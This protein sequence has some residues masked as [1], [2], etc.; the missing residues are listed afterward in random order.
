MRPATAVLLSMLMLVSASPGASSGASIERDAPRLAQ[1][2]ASAA[3]VFLRM[4]NE[5]LKGRIDPRSVSYVS[6]AGILL[7]D[8]VLSGPTGKPVA[9]V[10]RALAQVSLKALFSGQLL[11]SRIEL[12]EPKLLLE[13]EA[14]GTLNIV[15]ALAPKTPPPADAPAADTEFEIGD[16]IVRHGGFR[17]TDGDHVTIALDDIAAHASVD[18]DLGKKTVVVEVD[19]VDVQAASVKLPTLDV[20]L[21]QLSAERIRV[22]TDSVEVINVAGVALPR[23]ADVGARVVVNGRIDAKSPGQLRLEANVESSPGIWPDRLEPLPFVTPSIRGRV[24]VKGPFAAPV[25]D[26]DGA[27]GA[28]T[29]AGYAIDGGAVSLRVTKERVV[30]NAGTV[31][32][33][34]RGSLTATGT[35]LLPDEAREHA[36]LDLKTTVAALPLGVALAPA[37]LETPL[38]GTLGG[39]LSVTGVAGGTTS[40]LVQGSV[41]GQAL[42][43]FDLVLPAELDG[44]VRLTVGPKAVEISRAVLKDPSGATRLAVDGDIEL[45]AKRLNLR[46]AAA[47]E[48]TSSVVT[49]LPSELQIGRAQATGTVNGPFQ[50][51]VTNLD[52][53]VDALTAWGVS[54]Q[55]LRAAVRV[56][57]KEVRIEHTT[58]KLAEGDLSQRAPCVL[59]LGEKATTF[60]SGRFVLKRGSLHTLRTTSGSPLPLAGIVDVEVTLRGTTKR[61]RVPIR[62]AAAG[63]VVRGEPLGQVTAAFVA[64]HD[65]LVFESASVASPLVTAKSRD[66][67]LTLGDQRLI[68]T[69]AVSA[70]DLGLVQAARKISLRGR[71]TGTL[72]MNGPLSTP[73]LQ[74]TMHLRSFGVAGVVLGDGP[75]TVSLSPDRAGSSTALLASIASSTSSRSGQFETRISYAIDREVIAAELR[76]TD[77]D[78]AGLVTVPTSVAPLDG[79]V[80]G[81]IALSGPLAA[82]NGLVRLRIPELAATVVDHRDPTAPSTTRLR[83]LGS[84]FLGVQLSDGRFTSRFCAVPLTDGETESDNPCGGPHRVWAALRG[85]VNLAEGALQ[86]SIDGSVDEPRIEELVVAL[87]DREI[88]L[89]GR[90]RI[91]AVVDVPAEGPSS[92]EM[93]ANLQQLVARPPGAPVVTL[94]RPVDVAWTGG[95]AIIGE[96]AARFASVRNDLDLVIAGGS[97]IGTD[98]IDLRVDGQVALAALKVLTDEVANASG[99]AETHLRMKGRFDEGVSIDGSVTPQTGARMT[100]RSLGQTLVFEQARIAF[101]PDVADRRRLQVTIDG[102]CG[103]SRA[104]LCPLRAQLGDGRLQ[105][106]GS[107]L[108]HTS[109][110]DNASWI[111][112]FD[113]TMSAT[114]LELKTSLGR[115]ET[116]FDL[117]L[118]GD[119]PAPVLRGRVDVTD[120]FLRK[121]FQVR[122]FILSQAPERPSDPLWQRLAP[123][124][125]SGLML[126]VTASMQN[127]RTKARINAFSIDASMRGELRVNRTLK[128]PGIDGAIEVESGAVDFPRARFDIVEMQLQFPTSADG[129]IKPLLH[130]SA[131]AELPPGSA[132]NS[133]EVPVDLNLDG[134]F[135][136]MQLDLVAQDPNRQWTRSE[137][138]GHILFGIVPAQAGGADLVGTSVEVASRAALR[139]LTAPVNREVEALLENNLGV[140]VNIDLVSGFQVQLGRRVVVEGPGLQ[141]LAL[142][143]STA[144]ATSTNN[145]SSGTEAVRVRLLIYDHFPVGRAW[146]VDGRIGLLRDVRLTWRL[147]EQ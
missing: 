99:T 30:L 2:G 86:L 125:L 146:S 119:A 65:A 98:D 16:I 64:S 90:A 85:G 11:I 84:V 91:H 96:E 135:D 20:P 10:K 113:L 76:L 50:G 56:S 13:K 38:R 3:G 55:G 23:G 22:V 116:G 69:V 68:G 94:T 24:T 74:A 131:R 21:R 114:G 106:R 45:E 107:V 134:S 43:L 145:T 88:G 141:A 118:G 37:E 103:E 122:N 33:V 111:D 51:V 139:E 75:V 67:R 15:A 126:D 123:Y 143:D 147:Y 58:G 62:A 4:V 52:F 101:R 128:F 46:V 25:V 39:S 14:D 17:F 110:S 81:T 71:G 8:T 132:G 36:S 140:D 5:R 137:L 7:E 34:G 1:L 77:V 47:L 73:T 48:R 117:S 49:A 80:G 40:L 83:T 44:D 41:R 32:K 6:P 12:D 136:A 9:R 112:R 93:V 144:S 115:I 138:F 53:V 28:T 60:S 127:V 63:V 29:V 124:G 82:P 129:A 109:R 120:G 42:Q 26:V 79:V 104:E 89:G 66:L 18:I 133:V 54:G 78:L 100:L 61:P 102:P 72:I 27:L 121:E 35:V 57:P 59:A 97:S 108:A 92:V 95:R 130:L 70:I 87:A 31:L 19:H 142:T 105:L